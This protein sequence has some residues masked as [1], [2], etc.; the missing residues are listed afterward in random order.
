M[1]LL[2]TL[3]TGATGL[4]AASQQIA[5]T[6]DN[7]SNATTVDFQRRTAVTS[8]AM[9]IQRGRLWIGQGVSTDTISRAT[10]TIVARRRLAETGASALSSSLHD[11]LAGVESA[12]TDAG[13]ALSPSLDAF[14]GALSQATSDPADAGLRGAVLSAADRLATSVRSAATAVVDQQKTLASDVS[15]TLATVNAQLSRVADLNRAL[16]ASKGGDNGAADQRDGL[17][18]QLS[19]ELGTTVHFDAEGSATVFLG[20]QAVV[21]G[22]NARRLSL[23]AA[24]DTVSLSVDTGTMDVTSSLGGQVGGWLEAHATAEGYLTRLDTFATD[25]SAAI[26]TQQGLGLDLSGAAGTAVFTVP[27]TG[28]SS[29]GFALDSTITASKLAFSTTGAAGDGTNLSAMITIRDGTAIGGQSPL[30]ALSSLASQVGQDV[31]GAGDAAVHHAAQLTDLDQLHSSL[32][33]VDLDTE[34]A[35]L[36]TYQAAYQAAAKVIAVSSDLL[37]QLLQVA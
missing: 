20:G 18:R 28:H 1:S 19:T 21:S 17:L 27:G 10:D 12:L 23:N 7:V 4:R 15:G 13:G 29:T 5:A 32:T 34:A 26:N 31:S 9:A 16:Q 22:E 24:G 37:N 8:A 33:G 11:A 3:Q 35:H 14:F 36:M 6:T 30:D 25:F 2:G